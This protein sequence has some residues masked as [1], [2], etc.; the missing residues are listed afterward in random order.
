[1]FDR[2]NRYSDNG[3]RIQSREVG[4]EEKRHELVEAHLPPNAG[5]GGDGGGERWPTTALVGD[6]VGGGLVKW[7]PR[8]LRAVGGGEAVVST[9]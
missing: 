5:V 4:G 7:R 6:G 2:S 3:N 8:K 1:M 9:E